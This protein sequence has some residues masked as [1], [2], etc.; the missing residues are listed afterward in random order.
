MRSEQFPFLKLGQL[1]QASTDSRLFKN[2][3]QVLKE[4]A[5]N[6]YKLAKEKELNLKI[7]TESNFYI[8]L[9]EGEKKVQ[10]QNP[11]FYFYFINW[12]KCGIYY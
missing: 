9:F 4:S 12:K 3:T 2:S 8:S 10:Q 11:N 6:T 1:P 5:M 7:N